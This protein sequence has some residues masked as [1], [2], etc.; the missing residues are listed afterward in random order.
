M[1]RHVYLVALA[2]F[3]CSPA[4]VVFAQERLEA[5]TAGVA[6]SAAGDRERGLGLAQAGEFAAAYEL[7]AAWLAAHP[8][9]SEVASVLALCALN[10]GRQAEAKERLQALAG[11]D[12]RADLLLSEIHLADGRPYKAIEALE[13][14]VGTAPPQLEREVQ[15]VLSEAL[16]TVGRGGEVVALLEGGAAG[17]PKL[18]LQLAR[19]RFMTGDREGALATLEPLVQQIDRIGLARSQGPFQDLAAEIL[20]EYAR[21]LHSVGDA[22]GAVRRMQ[23]LVAVKPDHTEAWNVLGQGLVALGRP[24]EAGRAIANYYRLRRGPDGSA[25]D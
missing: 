14:R 20:T 12:L 11:T 2:L 18:A 8:E 19:G 4:A 9:D 10:T 3:P 17:D 7:L 16:L 24:D 13:P 15:R 21:A 6:E 22:S 23:D 25:G 5:A 1:S